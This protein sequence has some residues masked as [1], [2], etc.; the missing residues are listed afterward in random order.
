[1]VPV[2]KS[3]AV[4]ATA[5]VVALTRW[6][7]L[8]RTPW[9]WDEAQFCFAL[10]SYDVT[11]HHPHPP[12]FPLYILAAKLVRLVAP[13]DFH[14]LQTIVF[15]AACALFPLAYAAARAFRFSFATSWLGALLFVFL[16]N[17]WFYGGTAF[18]DIVCVAV[19][20]GAITLILRGRADT[21]T[22]LL[23]ALLLGIATGIRPQALLFGLAP[24]AAASRLQWR[25][26]AAAAAIVGAIAGASY[27][28][29]ALASA[30]V[31]RY[32]QVND[33]VGRWVHDVDAYTNPERPPIVTLLDD[34]WLRPMA[35]GRLAFVVGVLVLIALS[36]RDPRAWLVVASF[37]PFALLATL[38]LD[39][40]SIH[41]YSTSYVFLHALLA[42][43]GAAVVARRKRIVQCVVV[44][45]IA[46]RYAWWTA[47]AL[48]EVRGTSSP[49]FAAARWL[50][51]HTV[52]GQRVWVH[53]GVRPFADYILYDR[54]VHVVRDVAELPRRGLTPRD[55]YFTEG[56]ISNRGVVFRRPHERV[57]D[58]ARRRYF[59]TTVLTIAENIWL[60]RDGWYD[61]EQDAGTTWRWM[62]ARAAALLP[63]VSGSAELMLTL[64]G[65]PEVTQDVEVRLN[66]VTLERFRCT[67]TPVTKRWRAASS[68]NENV[69]EIVVARTHMVGADPRPLGVRL[70]AYGW[71]PLR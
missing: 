14:A 68:R 38:M 60:F 25:R 70:F 26:L 31:Q 57:W 20:L 47:P 52:R 69:L 65:P 56:V 13:D 64:A 48:A 34:F 9:D 58:I 37:A 45:L 71:R 55:F 32:R 29:A 1:M 63:G 62:G 44:A 28:G 59:E 35:G 16:P 18:S 24:L 43:E 6:F 51:A 22:Y 15:L 42:A 40:N 21:R 11:L 50:R 49:T 19:V 61:E 27:F 39:F 23:G 10:R 54:D 66:G 36:R 7:A 53:G 67:D 12:G 46:G 4:A 33:D 41:R 5:A 3:R 8:A 30:S 2:T 17:V